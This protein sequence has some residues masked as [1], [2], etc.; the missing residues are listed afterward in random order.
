MIHTQSA[1]QLAHIYTGQIWLCAPS[2]AS[3]ALVEQVLKT[4]QKRMGHSDLRQAHRQFNNTDLMT[5]LQAIRSE[6]HTPHTQNLQ[7][8]ILK[9][10]LGEN[11]W[12]FDD[13]RLRAISPLSH[14]IPQA[15]PA[16]YAHRD[17]WYANPQCQINFWIPLFDYRA[18]QTFCFYPDYFEHPIANDS[19]RFDYQEWSQ[20]VG[21]QQKDS[22]Q[23][24]T[25]PRALVAPHTKA[26]GFAAQ[27]GQ[28]LIFSG[29]HL[30]QPLP[31]TT[32]QTRWSI[33]FRVVLSH[34]AHAQKGPSN[35]DNASQGS[36]LGDFWP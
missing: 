11:T 3:Q 12:Q 8:H 17:T 21:W 6:I 13:L 19:E 2:K 31:N 5:H 23:E 25:Y 29:H 22:P 4:A 10:Q 18:E 32:E 36:T 24:A 33:D 30:H 9:E 35:I 1:P 27:R 14:Q 16:F 34:D 7:R 20:H 26:L 28:C 15:A